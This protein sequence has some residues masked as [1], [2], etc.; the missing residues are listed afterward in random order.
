MSSSNARTQSHASYSTS[1]AYAREV[2]SIRRSTPFQTFF[3]KAIQHIDK[4]ENE[5]KWARD[6]TLAFRR[7]QKLTIKFQTIYFAFLNEAEKHMDGYESES[8]GDDENSVGSNDTYERDGFVVDDDECESVAS[9]VSE[10]EWDEEA[11]CESESI[12]SEAEDDEEEQQPKRKSHVVKHK[13]T[14]AN[15]GEQTQA[16]KDYG[17]QMLHRFILKEYNALYHAFQKEAEEDYDEDAMTADERFQWDCAKKLSRKT[18]IRAKEI[19]PVVGA[20]LMEHHKA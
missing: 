2:D 7:Q 13:Q 5:Q 14:F 20:W 4:F 3:A 18:N 9:E 17:Q 10:D 1:V 12:A 19:Y 8:V 6:V 15:N 16:E 11:S